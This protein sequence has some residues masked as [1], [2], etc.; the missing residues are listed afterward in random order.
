VDVCP[1]VILHRI[2]Q[3]PEPEK[4]APAAAEA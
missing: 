2:G 3:S 4:A 1:S